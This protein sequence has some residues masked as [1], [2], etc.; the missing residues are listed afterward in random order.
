MDI[1]AN[2]LRISG[3]KHQVDASIRSKFACQ[4]DVMYVHCLWPQ[5]IRIYGATYSRKQA[6]VCSRNNS[7]EYCDPVDKTR[8]AN[9][10]CFGQVTCNI[11]VDKSTMGNHCP[12]VFKYLNILYACSKSLTLVRS[13]L[14]STW[15]AA[16]KGTLFEHLTFC[17]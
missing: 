13:D 3:A 8:M 9:S 11:T 12:D 2:L 15:G 17:L 6:N 14:V 1:L 5:V 4:D 7:A 16:S 10:L